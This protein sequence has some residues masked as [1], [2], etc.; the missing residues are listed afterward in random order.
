[1]TEVFFENEVPISER[2]GDVYFSKEGGTEESAYVFFEGNRI[3]EKW[4]ETNTTNNSGF[5]IGELGFGTGLNYFIT[6]EKWKKEISPPTVSF[7]SLEKFPLESSTLKIMKNHFPEIST[8]EKGLLDSYEKALKD[9]GQNLRSRI[10][11]WTTPHPSHRTQFHLHV[12]FSDVITTLGDWK[13]KI[14]AWYLDGFSPA[15]NPEMWTAEVFQKIKSLSKEGTSFAT[16]TAAGF[17]R[18]N[19]ES[20]GFRVEKQAGFG[21]KREM[22]VGGI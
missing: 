9:G 16:F 22:L 8:W 3:A 7:F 20:V 4:K 17:V 12:Y 18:R 13:E 14:D 10:W 21:R 2:F 6:L 1:M 11:T 5:T 19:L 15:K